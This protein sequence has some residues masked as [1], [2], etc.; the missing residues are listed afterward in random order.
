ERRLL[1]IERRDVPVGPEPEQ[2][3]IEPLER[4]ELLV[5]E[6]CAF[7]A[8]ELAA[9][10]WQRAGAHAIEQRGLRHAVVRALVALR[11][12]PLVAPPELDARPVGLAPG[13][14]LVWP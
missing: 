8:A 10:P 9:R 3:E 1:G 14:E 12:A 13:R 7:V 4:A 5:V 11:H 2:H 6:P